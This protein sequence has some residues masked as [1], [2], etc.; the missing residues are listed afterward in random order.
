MQDYIRL[1]LQGT[2]GCGILQPP[3]ASGPATFAS[4]EVGNLPL[5][6]HCPSASHKLGQDVSIITQVCSASLHAILHSS[7]EII[8][9]LPFLPLGRVRRSGTSY[10]RVPLQPQPRHFWHLSSGPFTNPKAVLA[11]DPV[12]KTSHIQVLAPWL[13]L[14]GKQR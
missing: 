5:S 12:S 2:S 6:L 13:Y 3:P 7:Q 4:F 1:C 9:T 10:P 8:N 11:P 14:G